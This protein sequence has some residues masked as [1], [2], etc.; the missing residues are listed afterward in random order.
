MYLTGTVRMERCVADER[1][2]TERRATTDRAKSGKL[3]MGISRLLCGGTHVLSRGHLRCLLFTLDTL[4]SLH[5]IRIPD[6][7][8]WRQ[9]RIR[10]TWWIPAS[11]RTVCDLVF[12]LVH[13]DLL[14]LYT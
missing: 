14:H 13:G 2:T 8:P 7:S 5:I 4:F 9:G 6:G 10:R 11:A 12:T 1:E 3:D